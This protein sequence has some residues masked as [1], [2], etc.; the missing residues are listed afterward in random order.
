M[1][2]KKEYPPGALITGVIN[3]KDQNAPAGIHLEICHGRVYI[4]NLTDEAL[5]N[6]LFCVQP[7]DELFELQGESI[8]FYKGGIRELRQII[9]EEKKMITVHVQR[10]DPDASSVSTDSSRAWAEEDE[11]DDYQ[12]YDRK[13]QSSKGKKEVSPHK[14]EVGGLYQLRKLNQMPELNGST[15]EVVEEDTEHARWKVKI[16]E[17]RTNPEYEGEVISAAAEKLFCF[18]KVGDTMKLKDLKSKPQLN[19]CFVQIKELV[20]KK[21][22]RWLV[23]VIKSE[24]TFSVAGKN[25]EHV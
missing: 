24:T 2:S 22:A 14:I 21:R 3:K 1:S 11:D 12:E 16:I 13:H 6:P 19:G 8:D 9:D 7:G 18:I 10:P 17:T 15:V 23:Y 25:L 5:K 4:S 20:D